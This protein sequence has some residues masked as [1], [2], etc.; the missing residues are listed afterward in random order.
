MICVAREGYIRNQFE[1]V[2][3]N[4][5][6]SRGVEALPS[7]KVLPQSGEELDREVVLEKVRELGVDSVLVARSI[8]KKSVANHQ[9]G[10]PLYVPTASYSDG[11]FSYYITLDPPA[12]K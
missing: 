11:W 1:N 6:N 5:L 9:D 10:G 3:S 2:L 4:K 12:K 7:H 8:K